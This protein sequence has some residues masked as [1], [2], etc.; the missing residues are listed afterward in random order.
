M[1]IAYLGNLKEALGN[2]DN[3]AH[4][5]HAVDAGFDGLGV[6]GTGS[7][8]DIGNLLVLPIGP[9]AVHGTEV[10]DDGGPDAQQTEGDDGL[11][12]DDIVLV[13]EGVNGQPGDGGHDGG[14]GDERVAGQG[15]E[16]G[17]GLLLWVLGRDARDVAVRG[18]GEAGDGRD[19][20][21][22]N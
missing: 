12:V 13:A 1:T 15:I 6:V 20:S 14:L 7:V 3:T 4:L 11:L 16:N 5:L 8:Q 10:L 22:R 2:I 9:F 17:L 21:G 18:R 19:G